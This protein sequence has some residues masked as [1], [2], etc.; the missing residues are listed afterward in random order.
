MSEVATLG[1]LSWNVA[2]IGRSGEDV[3]GGEL[4]VE[5][6]ELWFRPKKDSEPAVWRFQSALAEISD[7]T[8]V[9]RTLEKHPWSLER[10]IRIRTSKGS[11]A[12]FYLMG[13]AK[14]RADVVVAGISELVNSSQGPS[15]STTPTSF[16]DHA[17]NAPVDGSTSAMRKF[18]RYSWVIGVIGLVFYTP[19]LISRLGEADSTVDRLW[20]LIYPGSFL[21]ICLHMSLGRLVNINSRNHPLVAVLPITLYLVGV[22][23]LALAIYAFYVIPTGAALAPLLFGV[24]AAILMAL[25]LSA[26]RRR[27]WRE[28]RDN[29][30]RS[31]QSA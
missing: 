23:I 21:A 2:R 14:D 16:V 11:Q 15:E 22:S 28:A 20:V 4:A 17:E 25:V 30:A 6:H 5:G 19:E 29:D 1:Q 12:T 26:D 18:R 31:A 7:V 8:T 13:R 9:E 27:A 10:G 3:V 24:P